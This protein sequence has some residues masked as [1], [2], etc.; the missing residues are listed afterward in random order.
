MANRFLPIGI[1]NFREIRERNSYYVDKTGFAAKLVNE[2]K[3]YFLARPRRFGKSLFV[4]TLKELFEGN[5]DLFQGL[6]AYEGWDWT[7]RHPVVRLDFAAVNARHPEGLASSVHRQLGQIEQRENLTVADGSAEGRLEQVIRQLHAKTGRTVA[8]LVD[9]YD[10]P[11]VDVL[12]RPRLARENRDRL[13]ILYSVFQATDAHIRFVFLTGVSNFSKASLF[14]GLNN[15]IDITM[16]PGYGNICGY[17]EADIDEVFADLMDGLDRESVR[18]WYNGY[19]WGGPDR[20]YNPFAILLLL[21]H[22]DSRP[23]W[24]E[25]GTPTFL[26]K[27]LFERRVASPV[28][29]GM[30]ASSKLLSTFDV[31]NMPTGALLFQTGYLTVDREE[32]RSGKAYYRLRY[33]NR[34]VREG[35]NEC[36]LDVLLPDQSDVV[37]QSVALADLLDNCDFEGLERRFQAVYAGIPTDWHRRNDIPRF[38]GYYASVFYSY[39][40]GAGLPVTVEDSSSAGRLDMAVVHRDRAFLFKF[41]VRERAGGVSALAQLRARGYATKYRTGQRA[42][43]LVGVE[44]SERTRNVVQIMAESISPDARRATA[45]TPRADERPPLDGRSA[46]SQSSAESAQHSRTPGRRP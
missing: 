12:D 27:V 19:S 18:D 15:L 16:N 44:F 22:R 33:P 31:G 41:K 14:T 34:E 3:C 17:T 5:R 6:A 29:D 40:A 38:E 46:N 23:W 7:A 4:D 8:V 20:V 35:L 24:F 45:G 42:V 30:L 36:L 9:E 13:R 39:F 28:L 2:G 10:K 43:H 25:S 32:R 11:I 21:F 1:Q 37:E 26:T